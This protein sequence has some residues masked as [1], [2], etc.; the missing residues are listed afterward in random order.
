M[1]SNNKMR[2]L[3]VVPARG[4]SKRV[5][6]KNV[7]L[8]NGAPLIAHTLKTGLE[9][10][11]IDTLVVSTDDDEIAG[12][13]ADYGV[14]VIRRPAELSSDTATTEV[15]LLH[16]LDVLADEHEFYDA[17]LVL[18]PTSPLRTSHTI[19]KAVA[20]LND[21][22]AESILAVKETRENIGFVSNGIFRPVV[23]DAPRRSQLRDPF[24][25]ESST[26]YAATVDWLRRTGTLVCENWGAL[27]VNDSEAL[28][29]NT[30]NDFEYVEFVL[31]KLEEHNSAETD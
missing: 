23:P 7:R 21:G 17:I 5:P 18:E 9:V 31:S 15:A 22:A 16:A 28:D 27:V 8:L 19:E 25:I 24:Y 2:V 4:G 29:I 11:A 3:A 10:D 30:E 12:I 20:M 26:I 13:A 14:R 6:R 1:Q